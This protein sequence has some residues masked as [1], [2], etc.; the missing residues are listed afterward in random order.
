MILRKFIFN[1]VSPLP[2]LSRVSLRHPYTS[3]STWVTWKFRNSEQASSKTGISSSTPKMVRRS[4]G[5]FQVLIGQPTMCSRRGRLGIRTMLSPELTEDRCHNPLQSEE[6]DL[7]SLQQN[8]RTPASVPAVRR[9]LVARRSFS[10]IV[11]VTRAASR[12]RRSS[13]KTS[14][15]VLKTGRIRVLGSPEAG[16]RLEIGARPR[17]DL[18]SKTLG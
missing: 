7:Q 3:Q 12:S 13:G 16:A 15:V 14:T 5:C 8:H 6:F 1:L 11:F 10:H 9:R 4:L 2:K 17:S 18:E